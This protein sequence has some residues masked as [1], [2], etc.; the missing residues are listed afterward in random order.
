MA[1]FFLPELYSPYLLKLKA[2]RMRKETGDSRYHHPHEN[3]KIDFKSVVTK[4]FT[5]PVRMLVT[6]PMVACI[7]LYASFVYGLLYMTL[8]VFPI[9][10]RHCSL[11]LNFNRANRTQSLNSIAAGHWSHRLSPSSPYLLVSYLQSSLISQTSPA[12]LVLLTPTMADLYQ[13]P[14]FFPWF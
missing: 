4:H 10:K 1:Y 13:K 2:Q 3:V 11:G 9:G 14:A 12:T 7:A 6:E 8:E 5:R